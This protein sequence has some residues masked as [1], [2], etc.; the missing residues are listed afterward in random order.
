MIRDRP[1]VKERTQLA[2]I[3]D[4]VIGAVRVPEGV[5][6][7]VRG[8][9]ELPAISADPLQLRQ[10]LLNLFENAVQA[11]GETGEVGLSARQQGTEA[12]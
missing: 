6:V 9:A 3:V 7:S 2:A 4:D 12:T 1:P 10:V 11:T 5:K 8:F